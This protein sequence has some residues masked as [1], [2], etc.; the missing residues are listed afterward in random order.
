MTTSKDK[1]Q[2]NTEERELWTRF[3]EGD[4]QAHQALIVNY[5]PLVRSL[6]NNILRSLPWV[7]REDLIQE[8]IIGLMKAIERYDVKRGVPFNVFAKHYIRG[9]ALDSQE[10]TREMPRRQEETYRKVKQ[11]EAELVRRLERSPTLE[12]VAEEAGLTAEQ[13]ANAVESRSIAFP[14]SFE[15]VVEGS[16]EGFE[17]LQEMFE[18]GELSEVAGVEVENI[19]W[20]VTDPNYVKSLLV[21]EAFSKLS[22]REAS[23]VMDY[24]LAGL[25][26]QEIAEKMGLSVTNVVKIR[27]RAINKLRT[28]VESTHTPSSEQRAH[29]H[30]KN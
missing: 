27:Q 8:G 20:D 25:T 12:E 6:V 18:S 3:R 22:E 5:L 15:L 21:E 17:R 28:F 9:A 2:I 11:A 16:R 26:H 23:I 4:Q 19:E 7:N 14:E 30:V 29:S 13:A 10:T 1:F 24:Y